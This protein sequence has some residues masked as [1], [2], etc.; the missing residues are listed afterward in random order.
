[1]MRV[2]TE[3]VAALSTSPSREGT[4]ALYSRA[5]TV[6]AMRARARSI[7]RRI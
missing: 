3:E 5:S 1:M 6:S 2:A 4:S 7:S